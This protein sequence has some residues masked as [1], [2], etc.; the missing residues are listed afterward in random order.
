MDYPTGLDPF[1]A[2][3]NLLHH[4]YSPLISVSA[5]RNADTLIQSTLDINL[6]ILE[7]LKPYGNNAK[8]TIPNQSFRIINNQLITRNYPSFPVRFQPSLPELLSISAAAESVPTS[9]S[10]K[11]TPTSIGQLFSIS[12][13]EALIKHLSKT[14]SGPDLY[15]TYFNKI[16]TPNS[17][18]PF[19][20]F[21]HPVALLFIIDCARDTVESLR[22]SIV[23]FRNFNFPKYFQIEDLLVHVLVFYDTTQC[24]SAQ[25]S[26]LQQDIKSHLNLNSTAVPISK[27]DGTKDPISLSVV[28]NSTIDEDLQRISFEEK[29]SDPDHIN[30][31]HQFD[32]VIRLKLYEFISKQLIPHMQQKIRVLDDQMLQPKKSIAGRFFLV[33]KK[34]FNNDNNT[35][36]SS[37]T[38]SSAYNHKEL[39]YY[40]STPEQSIRKLADWSLMLKDFK[41]A[42]STYDLIKKDYVNDKAWAYV[43]STQEMCI[44]SLLLAQTQQSSPGPPT[45]PDKSTLRKIRHDIVEPYMDNL[46]YTFK[47]RLN[48]KTYALKSLTVISELLLCICKFYNLSWKWNDLIEKYLMKLLG[49]F[50]LHLSHVLPG[51]SQ[52]I[53]A[54]LYERLGYSYGKCIFLDTNNQDLLHVT[55]P[56]PPKVEEGHYVNQKKILAPGNASIVGLTRF[57]KSSMWYLLS[58]KEWIELKHSKQTKYLLS[59]IS[60]VYDMDQITDFWYDRSDLLLGFVKRALAESEIIE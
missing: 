47:S 7:V 17:I 58:I 6:S 2:R 21:N 13:L 4:T 30:V 24:T 53:K 8:Y 48:L 49:E 20:T 41:Y 44:V 31:P 9:G 10:S 23:E 54:L 50:D 60:K 57:R 56:E 33:S 52:V 19:D 3:Q 36:S 1:A 28:E 55:E 27:D 11:T 42:Y 43:A 34:L 35:P 39:Y 32:T 29:N 5:S 15:L 38:T 46:S 51:G 14:M 25:V 45:V 16:I 59:N 37:S 26:A 18:V 40:K 12:S 22:A